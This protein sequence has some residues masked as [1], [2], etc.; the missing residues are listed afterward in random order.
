MEHTNSR[1]IRNWSILRHHIYGMFSKGHRPWGWPVRIS[2]LV[3]LLGS[4][5][6][7]FLSFLG[8]ATGVEEYPDYSHPLEKI[9]AHAWGFFQEMYFV[10]LLQ[11]HYL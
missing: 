8:N 5:N 10:S 7:L 3:L 2:L 4:L 1:W 9:Y 11:Q 6:D